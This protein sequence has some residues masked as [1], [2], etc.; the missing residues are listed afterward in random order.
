MANYESV[1]LVKQEVFVY[2]IPPRSTNRG[3][4]WV[5]EEISLFAISRKCFFSLINNELLELLFSSLLIVV[6]RAADWNLN[7]PTWNGR[8][9]MVTSGAQ[10][11]L[12]LE[13]KMSG[14]LFA[15][16]PV[17]AYPGELFFYDTNQRNV[18]IFSWENVT[19]SL[20]IRFDFRCCHWTSFGQLS[21]LCAAHSRRQRTICVHWHRLWCKITFVCFCIVEAITNFA[22]FSRIDR[23][24]L[25]STSRFKITLSMWRTKRRVRKRR[26]TRSPSLISDS[27]KEKLSKS[28]WKSQWV[29]DSSS[30]SNFC[31]HKTFRK[32]TAAKYH[33]ERERKPAAWESFHHR[34]KAPRKR[35]HRERTIS[36]TLCKQQH[37]RPPIQ[38]P[39]NRTQ[40]GF[41]FNSTLRF[42][43]DVNIPSFTFSFSLLQLNLFFITNI[44]G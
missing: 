39:S 21:V 7:E 17:E 28:T 34:Q 40:T 31:H 25:T 30:L 44:F 36:V 38:R 5:R 35:V 6:C 15:N 14:Q 1:I 8:M 23:T 24:R 37:R 26:Q 13:D 41:N 2:K 4:R 3:Y 11:N 42:S 43:N 10:L 27:K 16:C 20:T 18:E 19:S 22:L 33:R 32:K 12:K 29:D 9:R